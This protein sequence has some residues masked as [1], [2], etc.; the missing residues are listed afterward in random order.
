MSKKM[1]YSVGVAIKNEYGERETREHYGILYI[2]Y[3]CF[4]INGKQWGR[5]PR[6]IHKG[7]K[8]HI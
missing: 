2:N 1:K 7:F 4:I 8:Q 3:M 5:V 6:M